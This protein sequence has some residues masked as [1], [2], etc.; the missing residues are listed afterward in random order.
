[1]GICRE[2]RL[3]QSTEE[4]EMIFLNY[5]HFFKDIYILG[6]FWWGN[7]RESDHWGDPGVDWRIILSWIFRKLDLVI[8]TGL[9][10]PWIGIGGGR[11]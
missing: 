3:G 2:G 4:E 10:W 6:S 9:G 5:S 7:L 1:M 11:L 8:W